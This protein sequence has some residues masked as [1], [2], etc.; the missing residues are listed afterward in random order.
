MTYGRA[1]RKEVMVMMVADHSGPVRIDLLPSA[2]GSRTPEE[3]AVRPAVLAE[4]AVRYL[5]SS[6]GGPW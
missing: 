3:D 4:L 1:W 2:A 6:R 5:A